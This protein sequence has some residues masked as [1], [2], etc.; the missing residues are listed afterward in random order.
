MGLMLGDTLEVNHLVS[1][2]VASDFSV[3]V[4]QF[5]LPDFSKITDPAVWKVGITIAVVASLETL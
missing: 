5:T 3:F 4:N 1:I 2:P